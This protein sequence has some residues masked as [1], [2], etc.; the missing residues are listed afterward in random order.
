MAEQTKVE[1][2]AVNPK[3]EARKALKNSAL[4]V[5]KEL[6]DSQKDAKYKSALA[7]IRPSLY[8]GMIRT[9]GGTS[10]A[11]F[12][13][14]VAGKVTVSEDEVFKTMKLGRK[15]CAGMIRKHLKKSAPADRIWIVF[16][17]ETGIYKVEGKG[18]VP[19]KGYAGFIPTDENTLLK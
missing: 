17:A 4:A 13:A 2:K 11:K 19:P 1:V 18:A 10:F 5:L 7:A 9:S 8:G 12:V 14:F 15:D 3:R 6:C 16:N